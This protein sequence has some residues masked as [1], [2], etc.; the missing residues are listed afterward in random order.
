MFNKTWF[1]L[2]DFEG[3]M[4]GCIGYVKATIEVLGPGDEPTILESITD[5]PSAEKTVISPKL[6]PSGHLIMA[7]IYR[8]EFLSPVNLTTRNVDPIVRV[9][10]GGIYKDTNKINDTSNP[11]FNQIVFLAAVLPNHSKDIFIELLHKSFLTETLIGTAKV[12]FNLFKNSNNF[13]PV[14]LNIYGPP[15]SSYNE[16]SK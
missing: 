12:P 2:F 11:E 4:E 1:T 10:Y 5:D 13:K 7:E 16:Y 9:K 6:R 15:L 3:E 8:A 14:W